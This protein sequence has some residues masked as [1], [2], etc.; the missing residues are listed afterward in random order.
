VVIP[1]LAGWRPLGRLL[2]RYLPVFPIWVA[3]L[4]VYQQLLWRPVEAMWRLDPGAWNG[5]YRG[6]IGGSQFRIQTPAE[7]AGRA[8]APAGMDELMETNVEL[9]LMVGALCTLWAV[10]RMT[11]AAAGRHD[12]ER[13]DP[14]G[15]TSD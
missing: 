15:S 10:R 2:R 1:L 7:I 8:Q 5:I 4:F 14:A 13:L 3:V 12:H 6:N 9:L 11:A